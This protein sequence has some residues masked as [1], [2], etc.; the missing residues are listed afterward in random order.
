M[1]YKVRTESF[2]GPFDLL[3]YLVSRQRVDI[4]S[5]SI[6]EIADQY[7]EE[8][9]SMGNLDLD[10]ASD[11]LLVAATLLEMKAAS[12][13]PKRDEGLDDDLEELEPSQARDL[14][15][16]RLVVYKQ[17]KNAAADLQGRY[18]LQG[19]RH[20]RTFGPD[21]SLTTLVPDYLDG[22]SL[23]GLAFLCA[24]LM[25]RRDRFLLESEHIAAKPI[26]VEMHVRAIHARVKAEK[27]VR[28][29]QLVQRQRGNAIVVVTFLAVLELFKRGMVTVVQ[30]RPFGDMEIEYV[31]GSGE[32]FL[33]GDDAVTSAEEG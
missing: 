33:E 14:L 11:F 28:F 29:S 15:V 12:L 5:I 23:D 27:H 24:Q 21:A 8:V 6:A 22:V 3:L 16:Q 32:L 19:R 1:S 18:E 7:L 17:F 4:G 25:G 2:E 10:V 31:E 30:E 20:V 9:A 13:I 26:P